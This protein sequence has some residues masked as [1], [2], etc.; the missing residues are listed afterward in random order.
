MSAQRVVVAPSV[1]IAPG[2]RET[3]IAF[4]QPAGAWS[5]HLRR[6]SEEI[7]LRAGI[8]ERRLWFRFMFVV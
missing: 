6:L 1:E 4:C 3:Y 5:R 7:T 2:D 8:P